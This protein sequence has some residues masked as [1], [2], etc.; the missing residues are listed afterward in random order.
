MSEWWII[1][2][3]VSRINKDILSFSDRRVTRRGEGGEVSPALFQKLEKSALILEKNALIVS[4]LGLI[5]H[6][7][8]GFKSFQEKKK[9]IFSLWCFSLMCCRWNVYR[10][11][12]IPRKLPCPEKFLVTRLTIKSYLIIQ[13]GQWSQTPLRP[14][15]SCQKTCKLSPNWTSNAGRIIT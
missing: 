14:L 7:K 8:C 13:G 9:H 12:L 5:S 11:V 2:N 3:T 4:I 6:F 1:L 15:K 10:R